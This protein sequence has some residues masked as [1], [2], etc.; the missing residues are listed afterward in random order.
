[1]QSP[2]CSPAH[3]DFLVDQLVIPTGSV[4]HDVL[5]PAVKDITEII[6]RCRIQWLVF[7]EFVNDSTGNMMIFDE[8]IFLHQH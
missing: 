8:R 2:A 5:H 7:A 3:P 4:S 1:M 6:D